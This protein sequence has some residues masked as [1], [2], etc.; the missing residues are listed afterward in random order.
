MTQTPTCVDLFCGAGGLSLGLKMAGWT[1]IAAADYDSAACATF[2]HNFPEA[3]VMEGDARHVDWTSLRGKVDLVAGGPPCQPFSVAGHQRSHND[4]RDMLPEFVRAVKEIRPKLLLMENVAG[5]TTARNLP[6]LQEKLD[7]LT[8]L[9]YD[10]HFKVLNAADYGVAQDRLRVIVLGGNKGRPA[11]PRRSHGTASR[12]YRTVREALE[13]VPEDEPNRAIVT[14][15]KNPILRP[16]PW[17]GMLV[18][19]GGRPINLAEPSQTIPASA[20][21][22]RTHIVDETGVLLN[23]HAH[24]VAGGRP[25]SGIV[26]GVRRLTVCE[27]ARIQSFPDSFQFIGG[28]STRYRQ[29]GNAV[30]P[31]LAR[32]V[33]RSLLSA[34]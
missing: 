10:L 30:P 21:G 28:R 26:Q 11:F 32:A 13:G 6:Y 18:N 31:L 23:Y 9:G 29:V 14:Y 33:G 22:N 27:S 34:M 19:G 15:A 17:A 4:S 12:A 3:M 16:S 8:A 24:L 25:R 7:Q 20:G 1:A 2:R 5:L